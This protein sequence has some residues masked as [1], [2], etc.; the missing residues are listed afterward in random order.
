MSQEPI[1][2]S[3]HIPECA[4][5]FMHIK[6]PASVQLESSSWLW[7]L[8]VVVPDSFPHAVPR[9]ICFRSSLGGFSCQPDG[10]RE[11]WSPTCCCEDA[12][13]FP[14]VQPHIGHTAVVWVTEGILLSCLF[15]L[16]LLLWCAWGLLRL[17]SKYLFVCT[18]RG[19]TCFCK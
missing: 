2:G 4:G 1:K 3:T 5:G 12:V 11:L 14:P 7:S 6:A 8:R 9:A 16:V 13:R 18:I 15:S 17:I 19:G 10:V